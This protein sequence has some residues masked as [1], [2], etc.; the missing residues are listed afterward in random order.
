MDCGESVPGPQ[1]VRETRLSNCRFRY[2]AETAVLTRAKR[3]RVRSGASAAQSLCRIVSN[4][5]CLVL[6]FA[7][8]LFFF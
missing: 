6:L 8:F 5:L 1:R 7:Q 3:S 4:L 2:Y